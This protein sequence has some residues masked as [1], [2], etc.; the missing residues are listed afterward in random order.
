MHFQLPVKAKSL[1]PGV[2]FPRAEIR[3]VAGSLRGGA[4]TDEW[5]T[6]AGLAERAPHAGDGKPAAPAAPLGADETGCRLAGFAR[7]R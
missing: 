7:P 4:M 2:Q 3:A 5:N 6:E 1:S